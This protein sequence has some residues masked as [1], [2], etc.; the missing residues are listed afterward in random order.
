MIKQA[1]DDFVTASKEASEWKE[2]YKH[3]EI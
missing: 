1:N 3:I 2:K